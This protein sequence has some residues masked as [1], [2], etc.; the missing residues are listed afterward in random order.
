ME[1]EWTRRDEGGTV[2]IF[3]TKKDISA[4]RVYPNPVVDLLT[5]EGDFDNVSIFNSLGQKVKSDS[6]SIVN[7]EDVVSGIYIVKTYKDGKCN[8]YTKVMKK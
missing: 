6:N 1:K 7:M 2:G 4:V 8:G 5:I 3:E